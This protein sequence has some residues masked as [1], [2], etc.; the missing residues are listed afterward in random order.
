M[1]TRAKIT[2]PVATPMIVTIGMVM[3]G[4]TTLVAP[5]PVVAS[6][7]RAPYT[8]YTLGLDTPQT[9]DGMADN[10]ALETAIRD[11]TSEVKKLREDKPRKTFG[12]YAAMWGP[13]IA[14]VAAV[15]ALSIGVGNRVG[16]LEKK[17]DAGFLG[18]R[19]AIAALDKRLSVD[20]VK[21]STQAAPTTPSKAS[22]PS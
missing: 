13:G 2:V 5:P 8:R 3:T 14:V 17:V 20:E 12:D 9:M 21:P 6:D 11:L 10:A 1:P 16:D 4:A 15:I 7:L 22:G 19:D 18:V